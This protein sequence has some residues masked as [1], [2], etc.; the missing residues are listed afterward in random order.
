V[1]RSAGT[2]SLSDLEP[3]DLASLRLAAQVMSHRALLAGTPAA[4][5]FFDS[6]ATAVDGE[7]AARSQLGAG[8]GA[9]LAPLLLDGARGAEDR[10]V[11]GEY[12]GLLA[13]NERLPEQ[14]R[15]ICR[16]L[17]APFRQ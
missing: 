7:Q 2:A 5:L 3:S 4:A 9:Q 13:A 15:E 12:L 8:D 14:V 1:D 16:A 11:I 10:R 6:L 17:E